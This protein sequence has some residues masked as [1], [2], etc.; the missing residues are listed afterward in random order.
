M[1]CYTQS[2]PRGRHPPLLTSSPLKLLPHYEG[3]VPRP[4]R[5]QRISSSPTSEDKAP[6]HPGD[7]PRSKYIL[8]HLGI[9]V[10]T[11]LSRQTHVKIPTTSTHHFHLGTSSSWNSSWD[12]T[13]SFSWNQASP[14]GP[15]ENMFKA[16][17]CDCFAAA[18]GEFGMIRQVGQDGREGDERDQ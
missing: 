14:S 2:S 5:P 1:S 8:V 11:P 13:T 4:K 15:P 3:K 16:V 12:Q 9:H 6:C 7:S 17:S 10:L 18:E